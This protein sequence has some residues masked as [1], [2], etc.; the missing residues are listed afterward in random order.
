M[1][2]FISFELIFQNKQ[3]EKKKKH[4][5][6][7]L[8]K[9]C[10]AI[11]CRQI[12]PQA[13]IEEKI[14]LSAFFSCFY[15]F[16][17]CRAL[18]PG[19]GWSIVQPPLYLPGNECHPI[20]DPSLSCKGWSL[21]GPGADNCFT[22]F[23][24]ATQ[25]FLSCGCGHREVLIAQQGPNGWEQ[26]GKAWPCPCSLPPVLPAEGFLPLPCSSV[27]SVQN[28][29]PDRMAWFFQSSPWIASPVKCICSAIQAKINLPQK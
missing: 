12:R 15:C 6:S 1:K 22:S 27:S 10:F 7:T 19:G 26:W 17:V 11:P 16:G 13:D 5:K 2:I 23:S 28:P 14:P 9:C 4:R 25:A 21:P 20:T 29:P 18:W 24:T 8:L 3:K